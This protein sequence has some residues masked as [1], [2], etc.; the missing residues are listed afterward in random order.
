MS[1]HGSDE[2]YCLQ[3][4]C[5]KQLQ[6][7]TNPSS[8]SFPLHFNTPRA[9]GTPPTT[10]LPTPPLGPLQPA[11]CL[12]RSSLTSAARLGRVPALWALDGCGWSEK[13]SAVCGAHG[14]D[15]TRPAQAHLMTRK[16]PTG[17]FPLP[18][19]CLSHTLTIRGDTCE[20]E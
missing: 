8:A 19:F 13:Q 9:R 5:R 20:D 7:V 2:H 17:P 11:A 3:T 4:S 1:L 16:H 12:W 18:F 14:I 10:T 15:S 6:N